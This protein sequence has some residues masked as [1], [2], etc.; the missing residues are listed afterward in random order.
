MFF[1]H[2]HLRLRPDG[3]MTR[4]DTLKNEYTGTGSIGL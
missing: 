1:I 2:S 4:V 3:P